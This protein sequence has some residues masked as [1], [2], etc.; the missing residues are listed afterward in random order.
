[1]IVLDTIFF[2]FCLA[3]ATSQMDMFPSCTKL[4]EESLCCCQH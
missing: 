3:V 1:M 4:T 2:Y